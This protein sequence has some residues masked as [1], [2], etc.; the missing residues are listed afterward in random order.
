MEL[1][2]A[3]KTVIFVYPG[4]TV[5]MNNYQNKDKMAKEKIIQAQIV[6]FGNLWKFFNQKNGD[7]RPF[8]SVKPSEKSEVDYTDQVFGIISLIG[9]I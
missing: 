7:F 1:E 2:L 5:T 9:H 3:N 6:T 4:G 8:L